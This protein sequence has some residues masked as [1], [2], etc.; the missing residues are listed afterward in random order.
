MEW[1]F[2]ILLALIIFILTISLSDYLVVMYYPQEQPLNS[3]AYTIIHT[4]LGYP[5]ALIY[6]FLKRDL[7]KTTYMLLIFGLGTFIAEH[8]FFVWVDLLGDLRNVYTWYTHNPLNPNGQFGYGWNS[9]LGFPG[10]IF[11][12]T[13]II[14]LYYIPG[15]LISYRLL[16]RKFP[17]VTNIFKSH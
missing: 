12:Y 2:E 4:A 13:L 17:D 5:A 6:Y 16:I 7:K 10:T 11:T 15:V 1:K 3:M 9:F 14:L 8:M